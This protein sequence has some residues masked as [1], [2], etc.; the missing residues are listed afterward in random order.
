MFNSNGLSLSDIAAVTGAKN[1]DGVFGGDGWWVLIIL[2]AL[3]GGFGWNG[4]GGYGNNNG[5]AAGFYATQADLQRG[6]DQAAMMEAVQNSIKDPGYM[7]SNGFNQ[8]QQAIASSQ[9]A[10]MLQMAN[11]ATA[12]AQQAAGIQAAVTNAGYQSA[13]NFCQLQNSLDTQACAL[14]TQANQLAQQIMQN[15]NANYR[16]LH[17]EILANRFADLQQENQQLR[18]QLQQE[19][20][21]ASQLAQTDSIIAQLRPAAVPAY[22]VP[23]PWQGYFYG[24]GCC[25]NNA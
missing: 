25:C 7:V 15:D 9:D 17:D 4:N 18:T 21:A 20:L 3:F 1:N 16:Q 12:S 11:N 8:I 24:N 2:L 23:N 19:Q 14:Q 22:Q 6:F 13:L 10:V 5:A